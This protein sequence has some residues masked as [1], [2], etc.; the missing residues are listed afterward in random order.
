MTADTL[1]SPDLLT[2]AVHGVVLLNEAIADCNERFSRMVGYDRAV[3]M[4]KSLLEIC[5]EFQADGAVSR[6]RWQRRLDAVRG[7][8]SQW[9]A[10]QFRN[11]EG[12][13]THALVHLTWDA[14]R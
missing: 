6:E 13:R 8:S 12:R 14:A 11:G 3:L 10:W 7:G 1:A 5:P 9:F 2:N 4:G